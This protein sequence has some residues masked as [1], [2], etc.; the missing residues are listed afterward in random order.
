MFTITN[1]EV[2]ITECNRSNAPLNTL[3]RKIT[4]VYPVNYKIF[5]QTTVKVAL[6]AQPVSTAPYLKTT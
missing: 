1:P 3:L 5:K 6:L 2:S 4:C